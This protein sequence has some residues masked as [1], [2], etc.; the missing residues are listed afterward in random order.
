V[1]RYKPLVGGASPDVAPIAVNLA[2]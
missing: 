2:A 1:N